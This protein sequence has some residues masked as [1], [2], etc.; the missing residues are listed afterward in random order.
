M[1]QALKNLNRRKG[2]GATWIPYKNDASIFM[3]AMQDIRNNLATLGDKKVKSA[4]E[5]EFGDPANIAG[6]NMKPVQF[7][8]HMVTEQNWL[9]NP[10]NNTINEPEFNML[11][12]N[13][14]SIHAARIK[15]L[16]KATKSSYQAMV[17]ET[18]RAASELATLSQMS[19]LGVHIGSFII[20]S[21]QIENQIESVT[22]IAAVTT[23]TAVISA[24]KALKIRKISLGTPY[25]DFVNTEEVTFLEKNGVK[26]VNEY[27][28]EL[29]KTQE[30]RRG[31]GRVPPESL[32]RFAHYINHKDAD[33]IFLSC[34]NL[35][36][37]QYIKEL[38]EQ[39][40]KPI[41]TSNQ[42]TYWACLRKLGLLDNLSDYGVF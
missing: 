15:L 11:S 29:G 33:A 26:V 41:I 30:E 42:A 9:D 8:H 7:Y 12:P 18:E 20:P 28:L 10:I 37:I 6:A 31:I 13:G 34:T 14:I 27:G 17:A 38:E 21:S 19:S 1:G 35:A 5:D 25:V 23:S 32:Y 40:Q 4:I 39:L 3:D 2:A 22:G 16:G 24:L 36:T